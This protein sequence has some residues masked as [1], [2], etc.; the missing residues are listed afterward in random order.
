MIAGKLRKAILIRHV[1][2]KPTPDGFKVWCLCD[3]ATG[4]VLKFVICDGEEKRH[5][6]SLRG[7]VRDGECVVLTL[8]EGLQEVQL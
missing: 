6:Y 5:F 8:S 2:N 7:C 4:Y 3:S 1:H